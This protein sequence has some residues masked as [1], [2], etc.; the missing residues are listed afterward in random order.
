VAPPRLNHSGKVRTAAPARALTEEVATVHV[1]DRPTKA[2][3]LLCGLVQQAE[4]SPVQLARSLLATFPL[5]HHVGVDA[6]AHAVVDP[7]EPSKLL[8]HGLLGE[9]QPRP[10]LLETKV[11]GIG[12]YRRHDRSPRSAAFE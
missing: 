3:F 8:G 7:G 9:V 2:E 1:A 11:R 12:P 6:N 10:V 4:E 5:P